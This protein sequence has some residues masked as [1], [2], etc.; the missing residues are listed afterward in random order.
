[1]SGTD[2]ETDDWIGDTKSRVECACTCASRGKTYGTVTITG[3]SGDHV[4]LIGKFALLVGG[5]GP[6]GL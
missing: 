5:G 2:T 4:D 6:T 3:V 1:M